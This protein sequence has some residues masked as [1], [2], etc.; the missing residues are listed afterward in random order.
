MDS[1]G[2]REEIGRIHKRRDKASEEQTYES[3]HG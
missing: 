3:G 2:W 1:L